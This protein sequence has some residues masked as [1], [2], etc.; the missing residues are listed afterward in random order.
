MYG[1][2]FAAE[3]LF[4]NATL[5]FVLLLGPVA[6]LPC[7][8]VDYFRAGVGGLLMCTLAILDVIAIVL[9]NCAQWGFAIHNAGLVTFCLALPMFAMGSLL[10]VSSGWSGAAWRRIWQGECFLATAMALFFSWY[11]GRDGLQ[12]LW[13]WLQGGTI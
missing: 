12:A 11:V 13:S 4:F 7:T 5:F 1:S 8:I 2:P 10:F 9:N 6:I 3:E